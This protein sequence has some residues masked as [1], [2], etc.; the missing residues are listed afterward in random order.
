M[1]G[2]KPLDE[3][4]TGDKPLDPVT[5][6]K[7]LDECVTGDKPLDSVTG[8][9][10]VEFITGRNSVKCVD[11]V[12]HNPSHPSLTLSAPSCDGSDY[13][14][15]MVEKAATREGQRKTETSRVRTKVN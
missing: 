4:V 13:R 14:E 5:A 9:G 12:S 11:S 7:P 10:A 6:N 15:W 8:N 1:T 3:C 2:D